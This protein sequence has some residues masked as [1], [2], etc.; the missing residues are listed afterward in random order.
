MQA[1][2]AVCFN[3]AVEPMRC[4]MRMRTDLRR[5]IL[6]FDWISCVEHLGTNYANGLGIGKV[7]LEEVNPHLRGGRVENHLGKTTSS[8][9]DRDSNLDLPV[10]NGRAQ[11]DKRVSQLRHR[12]GS[13]KK[14][15]RTKT[16]YSQSNAKKLDGLLHCQYR[17]HSSLLFGDNVVALVVLGVYTVSVVQYIQYSIAIA[18]DDDDDREDDL[19]DLAHSPTHYNISHFN[20]TSVQ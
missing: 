20:I 4:K 17:R 6:R 11:H 2:E 5:L 1:N 14:L 18:I 15:A 9:P 8:S 16:K 19:R 12:G 10:L 7:V 3:L 13:M